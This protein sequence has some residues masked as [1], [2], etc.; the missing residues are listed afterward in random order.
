MQFFLTFAKKSLPGLAAERKLGAP[1]PG[2]LIEADLSKITSRQNTSL[3]D[4]GFAGIIDVFI[5]A[6]K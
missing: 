1:A 4:G 5:S 2:R 6:R 3:T